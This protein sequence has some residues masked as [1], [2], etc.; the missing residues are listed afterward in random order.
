M[1]QS[2]LAAAL[3]CGVLIVFA[4]RASAQAP[5][6]TWIAP[7][8]GSWSSAS[9]WSAVPLASGF[10]TI[11]QF[12]AAGTDSYTATNDVAN[13]FRLSGLILN[14]SSTNTITLDSNPATAPLLFGP[15]ANAP[16]PFINQI[17]SGAVSIN[18]PIQSF[19]TLII[20]GAGSGD[21]TMGGAFTMSGSPS[22]TG[23]GGLAITGNSNVFFSG[24]F[25]NTGFSTTATNRVLYVSPG[26]LGKAV[27][28]ANLVLSETGATTARSLS[29]FSAGTI[30]FNGTIAA[31]AVATS[32]LNLNG[33]SSTSTFGFNL[34]GAS[35]VINLGMGLYKIDSIVAGSTLNIGSLTLMQGVGTTRTI[36]G[37]VINN[38]NVN[39]VA[40]T[41]ATSAMLVGAQS[42]T[43]TGN[44]AASNTTTGRTLYNFNPAGAVFS[45]ASVFAMSTTGASIATLAGTGKFTFNGQ[46][47]NSNAAD[48]TTAS[49]LTIAG[50]GY[51][52]VVDIKNLSANANTFRNL[53]LNSGV[54]I[55]NTSDSFGA[56]SGTAGTLTLS[57]GA[58]QLNATVSPF[59]SALTLGGSTIIRGTGNS[60]IMSDTSTLT[61][62]AASR[63]LVNQ[64]SSIE[65]G[66]ITL[67]STASLSLSLGSYSSLVTMPF[68]F[69][70][71]DFVIKG[72]IANSGA[73]VGNIIYNTSGT[74]TVKGETSYTGA[75]TIQAGSLVLDFADTG[76]NRIAAGAGTLTMAGGTLLFANASSGFTQSIGAVT[77]NVGA[78]TIDASKI[79][80]VTLSLGAFTR[81][82]NNGAT[83]NFISPASSVSTS[84]ANTNNILGGYAVVDGKDWA[85]GGG[86]IAA[87]SSYTDQFGAGFNTDMISTTTNT[88]SG[89]I[90]TNTLRF[91]DSTVPSLTIKTGGS[92][93]L[94]AGGLLVTSAM[95][96]TDTSISGGSLLSTA[97][98]DLIVHQYN[99]SANLTISSTITTASGSLTKSGPGTL[100]LAVPTGSRNSYTG[101]T[102]INEGILRIDSIDSL[103][104]N[105]NVV[106]G[107]GSKGK[108][109]FNGSAFNNQTATIQINSSLTGQVPGAGQEIRFDGGDT[110]DVLTLSLNNTTTSV[111]A[112]NINS[113]AQGTLKVLKG[114]TGTIILAGTNNTF[115][116]LD[117]QSGL[118]GF[119]GNGSL[120]TSS[121]TITLSNNRFVVGAV[122]LQ[123]QGAERLNLARTINLDSTLKNGVYQF[124]IV[125]SDLGFT[126]GSGLIG[127]TSSAF[128][129]R[130][131]AMSLDLTNLSSGYQGTWR[132]DGVASTTAQS[133][134]VFSA[135]SN[136]GNAV[137][138]IIL[139]GGQLNYAGSTDLT[140]GSGHT[141]VATLA[142]V[143]G[144]V[145]V[146]SI[147]GG[148]NNAAG[149]LSAAA[150]TTLTIAA[151][152]QITGLGGMIY[153]G[154]G[155]NVFDGFGT[156][157]I[158]AP[159]N[160]GSAGT[161]NYISSGTLAINSDAALGSSRSAI[162][163]TSLNQTL[164]ELQ[165]TGNLTAN[166]DLQF[167]SGG[168][169]NTLANTVI[170]NG[171]VLHNGQAITKYGSGTL[172][173]GGAVRQSLIAAGSVSTVLIPFNLMAG[174]LKLN[175]ASASL[176]SLN[177][178][179]GLGATLDL[180]DF[181]SL[182]G[183]LGASNGSINLG[184]NASTVL[185]LNSGT[186]SLGGII[187]GAG[188][189]IKSTGTMSMTNS[190][191]YSGQTTLDYAG[192]IN[193]IDSNAATATGSFGQLANTSGIVIRGNGALQAGDATVANNTF[194]RVNA[195][196]SL[197]FGDA[198]RGGG[199]FLL[200]Q[201][202]LSVSLAGV[203]F[204]SA[205][206]T[207]TVTSTAGLRTGMTV[208]GTGIPVGAS[209]TS[210]VNGTSFKIS[211]SATADSSGNYTAV[212][213]TQKLGAL[214]MSPGL[215][216]VNVTGAGTVPVRIELTSLARSSGSVLSVLGGGTTFPVYVNT[217]PSNTNNILGGWAI[218]GTTGDFAYMGG[219]G[220]TTLTGG[221]QTLANA[222]VTGGSA[223]VVVGS[224]LN[225]A[226]G[227]FISG[228]NIPTGATIVS[229]D[230]QSKITISGVAGTGGTATLTATPYITQNI[231]DSW[232][233][234]TANYTTSAAVT[235]SLN[236]TLGNLTVNSLRFGSTGTNTLNIDDAGVFKIASGGL[237]LTSSATGVTT[238]QQGSGAGASLTTSN[239]NDLVIYTASAGTVAL[240]VPITGGI[241]VIK[242]GT[243][244][245]T[246]TLTLGG[247]DPNTFTGTLF[248]QTG[249]LNLSKPDG[250]VS[251]SG[252]LKGM[253]NGSSNVVVNVNA[254]GQFAPNASLSLYNTALNLNNKNSTPIVL[255]SL[256]FGQGATVTGMGVGG[257]ELTSTGV[258]LTLDNN[259]A[260]LGATI[261]L[262]GATGGSIVFTGLT[263]ATGNGA[264]TQSLGAYIG[265]WRSGTMASTTGSVN[266][267]YTT[268]SGLMPNMFVPTTWTT[269]YFQIG[270]RVVSVNS[271]TQVS[272]NKSP[273]STSTYS[274]G[275]EPTAT[276]TT[277]T[278]L[279]SQTVTMAG[280]TSAT[281]TDAMQAG[282]Y[283]F[284]T[285]FPLGTRIQSVDSSTQLTLT[286]NANVAS[287]ASSLTFIPD[288]FTFDLGSAT[289]TFSIAKGGWD[290]DLSISS[291][292]TG[293]GGLIKTGAGTLMLASVGTYNTFAG[294][295]EIQD[296]VLDINGSLDNLGISTKTITLKN[297]AMLR[298]TLATYS[299][300]FGFSRAANL[301]TPSYFTYVIDSTG[302][303]IA[304]TSTVV[305]TIPGANLTGSGPLTLLG[306]DLLV[307]ATLGS[308]TFTGNSPFTGVLNLAYVGTVTA[309]ATAA[310]NLPLGDSPS[311]AINL[312]NGTLA[313]Q[314][315]SQT[316]NRPVN[317][318]GITTISAN[319]ALS[320][321]LN[322]L[323]NLS[324]GTLSTSGASS[325]AIFT[326]NIG[327]GKLTGAGTLN[328]LQNS[329]VALSGNNSSYTGDIYLQM[330]TNTLAVANAGAAG[331]G[332]IRFGNFT[333]TAGLRASLLFNSSTAFKLSNNIDLETLVTSADPGRP[334][335]FALPGLG[336][337]LDDAANPI[338]Q[339]FSLGGN[340]TGDNGFRIETTTTAT[341]LTALNALRPA[342]IELSGLVQHTG[343]ALYLPLTTNAFS[344]GPGGLLTQTAFI[345]LASPASLPTGGTNGQTTYLAALQKTA[346]ATLNGTY[347]YIL[348][349]N[350]STYTL[351]N[352]PTAS[353]PA[354]KF[355]I[356]GAGSSVNFGT[357][358]ADGKV[359]LRSDVLIHRDAA[360]TAQSL[361]LLA[362]DSSTFTLGDATQAV[363]FI[364]SFGQE[365]ANLASNSTST[366][367]SDVT[368][369]TTTLIKRGLGTVVLGSV[370]YYRVDGTTAFTDTAATT[371]AGGF[372]WQIGRAVAGNFDAA[373]YFDG[374]IRGLSNTDA[375]RSLANSLF[376]TTAANFAVQLRGGV[377]EIDNT[378]GG[379]SSFTPIV[380]TAAGNVNWGAGGGGFSAFGGNVIVTLNNNAATQFSFGQTN[381]AGLTEALIFGSKTAS[382]AITLLNPLIL[383]N[384]ADS[385]SREIRVIDNPASSADRTILS[386]GLLNFSSGS[387]GLLKTGDGVLVLSGASDYS[388]GTVVRAGTLIVN[389][390]AGSGTG[391]G[392]V[393]VSS[394]ATLRGNG[395]IDATDPN[396]VTINSGA[397]IRAGDGVVPQTLTIDAP[398][399]INGG[400]GTSGANVIID[401]T[402]TGPSAINASLIKL[403]G[404]GNLLSLNNLDSTTGSKINFLI[405]GSGLVQGEN[406]QV[407]V[408][409]IS[410][411]TLPGVQRNG[412]TVD[413]S[414]GNFTFNS[415]EYS[416]ADVNGLV[417]FS[418]TS[419][420]V[421]QS[422]GNLYLSFTAGAA[423]PEPGF[424]MLI[425]ASGLTGIWLIVRRR[426]L[427]IA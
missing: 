360:T 229:I 94:S 169:I 337:G 302:G 67:A 62:G 389:N 309:T 218:Y 167:T 158:T 391:S 409:D 269:T 74:T 253:G 259:S 224:T 347:G 4:F 293:S 373:G 228:T 110:K 187:T 294:N 164:P 145:A 394:G 282:Y 357:L 426:R 367:A 382:A 87:N 154:Y 44:F 209:I 69:G 55:A 49:T 279:N 20:G 104:T 422:D 188:S 93:T 348:A 190:G 171:T 41:A 212:G 138:D 88:L 97:S 221:A 213:F 205:S 115:A 19:G 16:I 95:G 76:T 251:I 18:A 223:E 265:P 197:S 328:L 134:L 399:A 330:N 376:T 163:F 211:F 332:T 23:L 130:S 113:G 204:T 148:L 122:G 191:F 40:G 324:S 127:G 370:Q 173:L 295:V 56:T 133:R 276:L 105:S 96:S 57:G 301:T 292:V 179:I 143:N 199:Q 47:I 91:N 315:N 6:N 32:A 10:G 14:S 28:F 314:T 102:F 203:T 261:K 305:F 286:N 355:V 299:V 207:I 22:S 338:G 234:A 21:L 249:T 381:F 149:G 312:T 42:L 255:S 319:V 275:L 258:A 184:T 90:I 8:S 186:I 322:G 60:F 11:L 331:T 329:Y 244:T 270:T 111:F 390:T 326:V 375:S 304:N 281:V 137:N 80:S 181:S 333:Q 383:A 156:V 290:V 340:I 193:L 238:F 119:V 416:I 408:A 170:V 177:I 159:Q 118:L 404:A 415:G 278:V 318:S 54:L 178:T 395:T 106:F 412:V 200:G 392:G 180:N 46:M 202:S 128:L 288:N 72:K 379:S 201:S 368:T 393:T 38:G 183:N 425:A 308:F 166:R 353:N 63:N 285:A 78:S 215:A 75:T 139:N 45:D 256:T 380:G 206:D 423:V 112:G 313:F 325:A 65:L 268:T 364:P 71:G 59:A 352:T 86:N 85:V 245:T 131:G 298:N 43:F 413:T 243:S 411:G 336:R 37:T 242:S 287:T 51:N 172:V 12:N 235:G 214:T 176:S 384:V 189:L 198:V 157:A 414:A 420:F 155:T 230:S 396:P 271:G 151:T 233:S 3:G 334:S 50:T 289:R 2:C 403:T 274:P 26:T 61:V 82:A 277:T 371:A 99:A 257:F 160:Y 263:G 29:V 192:R 219:V 377:Y 321:G 34:T 397:T 68:A 341:T 232:T 297:N 327:A 387:Q 220:G 24:T 406:Y 236:S 123:Y 5:T 398:V 121:T 388:G 283:V 240:N 36:A 250:V 126:V 109:V 66:S 358:G 117:V 52:L 418:G 161:F 89:A 146:S 142:N 226:P 402:R 385:A 152:N 210:I 132:V 194:A 182:I 144:N 13:P 374:A 273:N 81:T 247:S 401:L 351:A 108:L 300:N 272:Y 372:A 103:P 83:I 407:K 311:N 317:L 365:A 252:G 350:N 342:E 356:G 378:G 153:G 427:A 400:T 101:S 262:S 260:P 248:L 70:S 346:A 241:N 254:T 175:S 208:T 147:N 217:P 73:I 48:S 64:A 136:L 150:G 7:N 116:A 291:I 323:V 363:R 316:Y 35:G 39:G 107:F 349:G 162:V 1:R 296:G 168:T 339:V 335:I 135:D 15:A 237:L 267:N 125:T 196:A 306:N 25:T 280:T 231:S 33:A 410:A 386:G 120:G 366:V 343:S 307:D 284:S 419:L 303:T 30:N 79:G 266:A 114:N 354:Y 195:G 405:N 359:L 129:I 124:D 310:G 344:T 84:Q 92:L 53:T 58:I 174:T 216:T 98:T 369:A 100:V 320:L 424:V 222:T 17:N 264:G 239:S 345:R 421:K 9:N 225:L 227:M 417:S 165:T 362:R 361:V 77:F 246:G 185:T 140:L 31:G 27:T 141:I